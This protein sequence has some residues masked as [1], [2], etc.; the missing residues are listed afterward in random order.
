MADSADPLDGWSMADIL[1]KAPLAK[2]DI[3]GGLF[4]LVQDTLQ[5]FCHR[6]EGLQVKFQ[7]LHGDALALPSSIDDSKHSFDRIEVGS[8]AQ[9]LVLQR[10]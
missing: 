2:N 3:Y 4:L 5:R 1:G 9:S 7:L 6:I 10:D 8:W